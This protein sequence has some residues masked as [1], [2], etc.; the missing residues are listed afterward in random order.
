MRL[1][2]LDHPIGNRIRVVGS[3]GKSSLARAL[4]VKLGLPVIEF[5]AIHWL[6]DWQER[7]RCE[8]ARI[9]ETSIESMPD[10]WICDG[11][12]FTSAGKS[13]V[14]L[15]DTVVWVR[16][17]W[18]VVMWRIVLRSVRRVRDKRRICGDNY[19]TWRRMFGLDALWL[20]HLKNPNMKRRHERGLAGLVPDDTPVIQINSPRELNRFYEV[21]GLVR[22]D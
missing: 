20:W 22:E 3:G 10:G 18:S 14:A 21:H 17:P 16:M 12:Y 15:A 13:S 1:V 7:P 19:E 2:Q 9:V 8:S 11:N 4:G 6:P 5:D